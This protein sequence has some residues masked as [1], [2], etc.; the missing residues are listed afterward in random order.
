MFFKVNLK[1]PCPFWAD[2]GHCS[3]R[4]CHVE[5]CPEVSFK[6]KEKPETSYLP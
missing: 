5:P 6:T 3:I 2:D 4:D 1:R